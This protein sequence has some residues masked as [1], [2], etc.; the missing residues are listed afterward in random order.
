ML[1]FFSEYFILITSTCIHAILINLRLP[2]KQGVALCLKANAFRQDFS[3][4]CIANTSMQMKR[5]IEI[6]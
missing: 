4:F 2:L 1:F 6:K 5:N 3:L